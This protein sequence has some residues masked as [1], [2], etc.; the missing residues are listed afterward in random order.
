MGE[1][2]RNSRREDQF[3]FDGFITARSMP[4]REPLMD[5]DV[6]CNAVQ[7]KNGMRCPGTDVLVQMSWYRC[8]DTDFQVRISWCRYPGAI[9]SDI[10]F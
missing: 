10:T 5:F 9:F 1:A 7:S 8:P 6:L 2:S 3:P 4:L